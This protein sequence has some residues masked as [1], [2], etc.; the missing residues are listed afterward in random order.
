MDQ[1]YEIAL[2][3]L[4]DDVGKLVQ[5]AGTLRTQTRPDDFCPLNEN[6]RRRTHWH[7]AATAAFIEQHLSHLQ[8]PG[9]GDQ[10]LLS[11]AARHHD[12]AT[13]EEWIVTVADRWASGLDRGARSDPVGDD[14]WQRQ[15]LAARLIPALSR[16]HG[17]PLCDGRLP[18]AEL[19]VSPHLLFPGS[20]ELS[21][22]ASRA[23]Y[24]RL[25]EGLV[26]EL[27]P[28]AR[29]ASAGPQ[30]LR[31]LLPTLS[32]LYEKYTSSIP[33]A[34]DQ[35][36]NDVSLFDHSVSVAAIAAALYR[37][38]SSGPRALADC[39]EGEVRDP[40]PS[41]LSL[42]VGDLSGI[43]SY[44]YTIAHEGAAKTLRGRSLALQ[45]LTDAA[46]TRILSTL[47]L[48]PTNLVYSGGGKLW[49]LA[50]ARA[51]EALRETAERIDRFLL[52]WSGGSLSFSLGLSPVSG[53]QLLEKQLA[54]RWQAALED[55][56]EN[57]GRRFCRSARKDFA[58]LFGE[59]IGDGG[60]EQPC[61]VCGAEAE[62]APDDQESIC[63]ACAS[64][65]RLGQL[66][67]RGAWL[68]RADESIATLDAP[69]IRFEEPLDVAYRI[70]TS[71]QIAGRP[72]RGSMRF[73]IDDTCFTKQLG[74]SAD[75]PEARSFCFLG[76]NLPLG[77]NASS[78]ARELLTYDEL[79]ARS[80]GAPYLGVLR[81]DVD[82]LS[83][84]FREAARGGALPDRTASLSR[85]ACLSR[86]LQ[87]FFAGHVAWLLSEEGYCWRS[88][89]GDAADGATDPGLHE[90]W[91]QKVQ[92]IYSGGDDLFLV[93]AWTSVIALARCIRDHFRRFTA[94][95][96]LT[97]SAGLA[98]VDAHHPVSSAAAVAGEL[99][100]A[101]KGHRSPGGQRKNA[102]ALFEPRGVLSWSEFEVA[103][104]AVE[105]ICTDLR[106]GAVSRSIVFRLQEVAR[107]YAHY[108]R[109][110]SSE[111]FDRPASLADLQ[112]EVRRGRWHWVASYALRRALRSAGPVPSW[113]QDPAAWLE[114]NAFQGES[115]ERPIICYLHVIARWAELR[116]RRRE[117]PR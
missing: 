81:M 77:D 31:A 72:L 8:R 60:D 49:L 84:L 39:S 100:A 98:V 74:R 71:Q 2:A 57:R 50:H 82:D 86:Q 10:Q 42:V 89:R 55:A 94:N 13:N 79:A 61:T 78:G 12:P 14:Y 91:H 92:L 115:G 51:E 44:L 103:Q 63:R 59:P 48:P 29:R 46:A 83:A 113:L 38:L 6:T 43:Q 4:L 75:S 112:E 15:V 18:L 19:G 16:A 47:Q 64:Q 33:A 117:G 93:G 70:D 40:R 95:P 26:A 1:T 85:L 5:R 3:G 114:A 37:E 21:A 87:R 116:T 97:L 27:E 24:Q 56:A 111:R 73:A 69:Q 45:L 68:L 58:S 7:A 101:A 88:S 108:E 66:L 11:F 105:Q 34:T 35:E 28:L 20:G 9:A 36:L 102:I 53:R 67:P 52:D 25:Y 62:R 65:R 41:R 17:R 107:S 104:R 106:T 110:Q 109:S 76:R 23:A 99:E 54:E 32:A 80:D 96:E 90:P 30:E 22:E